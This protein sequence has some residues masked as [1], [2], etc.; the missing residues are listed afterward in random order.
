M[1]RSTSFGEHTVFLHLSTVI[2]RESKVL[3][4]M[5]METGTWRGWDIFFK[6][7]IDTFSSEAS[8]KCVACLEMALLPTA[9]VGQSVGVSVATCGDGDEISYWR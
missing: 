7:S 8:K 5:L 2:G 4:K 9:G 1:R 6:R 3:K